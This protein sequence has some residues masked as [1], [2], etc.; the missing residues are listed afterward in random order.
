MLQLTDSTPYVEALTRLIR[1]IEGGET[2]F[3]S[4]IGLITIQPTLLDDPRK[5]RLAFADALNGVDLHWPWLDHWQVV[6][7]RL[8]AWPKMWGGPE[9]DI[10]FLLHHSMGFT[11]RR[12]YKSGY[13]RFSATLTDEPPAIITLID[14]KIAAY[15]AGDGSVG[16]PA[17]FPGDRTLARPAL[18]SMVQRHPDK[19]IVPFL[20][21][22]EHY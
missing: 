14:A 6:F 13:V 11:R 7:D 12:D 2:A 19:R 17:Y 18:A 3:A 4:L 20:G 1:P 9:P 10:A 16:L 21:F 8:Q 22:G 5:L 15:A